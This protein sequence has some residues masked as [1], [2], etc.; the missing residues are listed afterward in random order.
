M[1]HY[2]IYRANAEAIENGWDWD[3]ILANNA[4][5]AVEEFDSYEEAVQAFEKGAYDEDLYG[6]F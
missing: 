3:T 1:K 2:I 6:V 5:E 4:I